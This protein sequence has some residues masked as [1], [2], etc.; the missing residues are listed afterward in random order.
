MKKIREVEKKVKE[1]LIKEP[2]LRDSDTLLY[3]AFCEMVRPE[4][5]QM[6]FSKVM[7]N[8]K[9]LG[10]PTFAS[11][12]RARRKVQEKFPELKGSPE[13]TEFRYENFKMA[14]AYSYT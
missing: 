7:L 10:L 4:V 1:L 9:E 14:R 8:I 11:V 2:I 3:C 13:V 5:S 6:S 12:G